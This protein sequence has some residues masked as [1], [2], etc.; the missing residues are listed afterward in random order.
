[1][2]GPPTTPRC[3]GLPV[4]DFVVPGAL[5]QPTG[6]YVYDR[7]IVRELR[8]LG[9]EVRVH[10]LGGAFPDADAVSRTEAGRLQERIDA[11]ATL[12]ID[13]LALPAFDDLITA[14]AKRAT[15]VAL[16]HHPLSLERRL[17]PAARA[18]M[19]A[20]E[21]QILRHCR[22]V[23]VTSQ[24]TRVDVAALGIRQ[25]RIFVVE[26]ATDPVH[27][28]R[29]ARDYHP[30]K[31]LNLLCVGAVIERKGHCVL[32][33]ALAGLHDLRWRLDCVGSLDRDEA[34]VAR[35]RVLI[36]EAGLAERISIHGEVGG[37][38]LAGFYAEADLFVLASWHEGY[39]MALAEAMSYGV[40]VVST[41]AGAIPRTVPAEAGLLVPP[42]DAGALG[43]AVRKVVIDS[44][45][46]RRM[47]KAAFGTDRRGWSQAGREFLDAL[48]TV[49]TVG[50]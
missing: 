29:A 11:D 16:V 10:E 21:A 32:V 30:G 19:E 33:E 47:A 26:P 22:A 5:D 31:P 40:P 39:G 28:E 46:R 41:S 13:G 43:E 9:A 45:L 8:R 2:P 14:L 44:G 24:A 25:S 6:G 18:E 36:D 48:E 49:R 37:S 1:M 35:L 20:R 50:G 15:V 42:G 3:D 23:I 12:V 7:R 34:A 38:E 4:L 27:R 17:P